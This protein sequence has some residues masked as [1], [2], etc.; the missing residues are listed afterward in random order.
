M[1][2]LTFQSY[3]MC[4]SMNGPKTAKVGGYTQLYLFH[5]QMWPTCT[6]PAYKFAV[7]G[8][9][10][11]GG[12]MVSKH[13]KHIVQAEMEIC[14]WHGAFSMKGTQDAEQEKNMVCPVCGGKTI[15][16]LVAG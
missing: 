12:S 10:N 14:A 8:K 7:R 11:F 15:W 9:T 3:Q 1:P 5:V 4:E 16:V 13:C 6:C 2:D